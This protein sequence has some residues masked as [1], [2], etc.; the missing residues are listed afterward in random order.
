MPCHRAGASEDRQLDTDAILAISHRLSSCIQSLSTPMLSAKAASNLVDNA[1]VQP[2]QLPEKLP[3]DGASSRASLVLRLKAGQLLLQGLTRDA[4]LGCHLQHSQ[5]PELENGQS[6]PPAQGLCGAIELRAAL[7]VSAAKEMKTM[8]VA[9]QLHGHIRGQTPG[10]RQTHACR[11]AAL[12]MPCLR[13]VGGEGLDLLAAVHLCAGQALLALGG[14]RAGQ[15]LH[16]PG[17]MRLAHALI[18]C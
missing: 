17:L 13:Q 12:C 7:M 14:I 9:M 3:L 10:E 15:A 18:P 4:W 5:L 8:D 6:L 16:I 11:V 2:S 1:V